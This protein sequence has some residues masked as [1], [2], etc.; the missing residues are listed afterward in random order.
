M[1]NFCYTGAWGLEILCGGLYLCNIKHVLTQFF[2]SDKIKKGRRKEKVTFFLDNELRYKV[3]EQIS[4]KDCK[5]DG[6][7]ICIFWIPGTGVAHRITQITPLNAFLRLICTCPDLS[8]GHLGG[9]FWRTY[10]C[11]GLCWLLTLIED[12]S[13]RSWNRSWDTVEW[14]IYRTHFARLTTDWVNPK[15]LLSLARS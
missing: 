5:K 11:V 13:S 15:I 4:W 8:D 3:T 14:L 10:L 2:F 12:G 9:F 7:W 6:I 1:N